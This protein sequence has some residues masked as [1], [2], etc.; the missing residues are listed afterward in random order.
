[1]VWTI[2][3]PSLD[4]D[5]ALG[6]A[7]LVSTP[8]PERGLARDWLG[9]E[10]LAFPD[11]ERFYSG[12]FSL[13]TPIEVCCVYRFRHVRISPR[14]AFV[15]QPG[16]SS[17]S[18]PWRSALSPRLVC[19]SWQ[20]YRSS[21]RAADETV[22]PLN[23]IAFAPCVISMIDRRERGLSLRRLPFRHVRAPLS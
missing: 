17:E 3:S 19:G 8:S 14:S 7:R 15:P 23:H 21:N 13:G 20:H 9:P 1:M 16:P 4:A 18:G 5:R 11:F 2:P 10:P 6:A 12:D 22:I